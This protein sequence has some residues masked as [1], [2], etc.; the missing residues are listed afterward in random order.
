M[1]SVWFMMLLCSHS[2]QQAAR[3]RQME[4]QNML[5][6][7][8]PEMQQQYLMRNGMGNMNMMKN[9]NLQRQAMTNSQNK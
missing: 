3:Q 2:L 8:R 5:R 6:Q 9:N 7:M 1:L 4:Q